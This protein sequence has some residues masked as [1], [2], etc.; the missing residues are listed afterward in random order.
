MDDRLAADRSATTSEHRVSTTELGLQGEQ[1]SA[2]L[3]ARDMLAYPRGG[4]V[5]PST[6]HTLVCLRLADDA[7]TPFQAIAELGD[8]L[9]GGEVGED[10][11][12][13]F[14]LGELINQLPGLESVFAGGEL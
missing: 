6:I 4:V 3:A 10:L 13:A 12:A 8:E 7:S 2:Q 14:E 1:V 9:T 5:L 11:R